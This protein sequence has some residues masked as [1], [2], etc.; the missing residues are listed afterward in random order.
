[1]RWQW[2]ESADGPL[3]H[4]DAELPGV[5]DL[6]FIGRTR[7]GAKFLENR[8]VVRLGQV[9]GNHVVDVT[10][11]GS[12]PAT[13]GARTRSPDVVL[14][15]RTAD[16]V[17]AV[18]AHPDGV[19]LVHAG[20]RGLAAGILEESLSGFPDAAAVRVV[21]GPAIG[22]CCYE[23][24]PEVAAQFPAEALRPGPRERPHLDLFHA[25]TLRLV[26]RGVPRRSIV[27]APFCTRCHQH[28]LASARGSQG[29]P[30]RIIAF[31]SY[32]SPTAR[33]AP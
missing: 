23:V 4:L 8:A 21:L 17:P 19:A 15:I 5:A 1:M 10:D 30:E 20:W 32:R 11:P 2:I 31:A 33:Q 25:A 18:L 9:H 13:D 26:E 7:P 22:V 6:G 14:T 24:G 29:G 28:L 12:I 16:C 3:L 27:T